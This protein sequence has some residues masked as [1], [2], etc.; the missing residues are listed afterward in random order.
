[1]P[2]SKSILDPFELQFPHLHVIHNNL[3]TVR[4][5][6]YRSNRAVFPNGLKCSNNTNVGV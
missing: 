4:V 2:E 1:M 3:N 6:I 5:V